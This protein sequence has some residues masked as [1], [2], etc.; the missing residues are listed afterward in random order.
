MNT[1]LPVSPPPPQPKKDNLPVIALV[2]ALVGFCCPPLGLIALILAIV[3]IS[4]ASS[5]GEPRPTL[6]VIVVAVGAI[7]FVVSMALLIFGLKLNADRE[8]AAGELKDKLQNKLNAAS[9]DKDTACDLAHEYFLSVKEENPES[10]KCEGTLSGGEVQ[11]LDQV[12]TDDAGQK[13]SY[14]FC[15]AKAHRWYVLAVP[16]DGICPDD[17]PSVSGPSPVDRPGFEQEEAALR[18]KAAEARS[19]KVVDRFMPELDALAQ[20]LDREHDTVKCPAFKGELSA[21]YVDANLVLGEPLG[22]DGWKLL[23]HE[24]WRTALNKRAPVTDRAAA[25]DRIHSKKVVVVFDP[26]NARE[27]PEPQ[28]KSFLIGEYDGWMSLVDVSKAEV[29][30]EAPLKFESSETVGGG[31][32]LKYMPDKSTKDLIED[33]FEDKF[34]DTATETASKMSGGKLKL[35]LKLLE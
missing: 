4:R 13:T 27:W 8:K 24:D 35:G 21:S 7:A 1:D 33:D 10:V 6:A 30:C 29:I 16:G 2:L 5:R 32:K 34:K 20:A 28:G 31:V 26:T 19:Q 25:I 22:A 3:A 12:V 15:Y 23:S 9:L 11:R 17:A 14:V 18:K